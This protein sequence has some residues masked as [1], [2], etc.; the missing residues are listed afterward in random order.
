VFRCDDRAR[1]M[2]LRGSRSRDGINFEISDKRLS[3]EFLPFNRDGVSFPCEPVTASRPAW[4][5]RCSTSENPWQVSC[6]TKPYL[7][8]PDALYENVGNTQK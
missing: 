3:F 6:R 2:T 4:A 8:S 7:L 5:P 1:N